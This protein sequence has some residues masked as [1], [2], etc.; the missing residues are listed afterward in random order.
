MNRYPPGRRDFL[1]GITALGTA[2]LPLAARAGA[3][4]AGTKP[5]YDPAATFELAVSEVELRPNSV[6]RMRTGPTKR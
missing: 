6:G 1:K 2:C 3:A 4:A 5:A